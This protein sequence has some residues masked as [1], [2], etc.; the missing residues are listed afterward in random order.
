[1]LPLAVPHG[2]S[3]VLAYRIGRFGYVTD[4]KSLSPSVI[5]A[6]R[7]VD[8]LVLNALFRHAHP[9]HLSIPEAIDVAQQVA[10]RRTFFTHLTHD[11][12]HAALLAELPAGIEPAYD[13]LTV[14]I[15][16]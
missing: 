7:G 12:A 3:T 9:T 5:D 6:L 14:T 13:G 8:V 1:V 2:R 11:H 4:A 10:A 15:P 16:D